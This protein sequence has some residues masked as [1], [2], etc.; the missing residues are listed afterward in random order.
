PLINELAVVDNQQSN[1]VTFNKKS[2][3][4][5]PT[6]VKTSNMPSNYT[7]IACDAIIAPSRYLSQQVILCAEDFLGS[8]GA[9]TLFWSRDNW[10]SAEYLGAV[11]NWLEGWV[12]VT[13]LEVSNKV[14]YLPFA[15]F[16][17]GSFDS[18]GNR[19][20]FP[21]IEITEQVD[22]VVSRGKC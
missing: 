13:P 4:P 5:Q 3:L 20:S 22:R 12:V 1:L 11:F 10:E 15:P 16:D 19:S 7:S 17:G 9:V 8:N 21:I 18:L 14:Y 6:V 2:S